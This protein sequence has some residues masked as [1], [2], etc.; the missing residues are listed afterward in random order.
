MRPPMLFSYKILPCACPI[1]GSA[2]WPEA[3][4]LKMVALPF[5]EVAVSGDVRGGAP[6]AVRCVRRVDNLYDIC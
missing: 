1:H 6:V 4:I 3:C 5:G 2:R